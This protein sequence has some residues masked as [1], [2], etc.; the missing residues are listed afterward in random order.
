MSA[1][2]QL[3]YLSFDILGNI[4]HWNIVDL[5]S[6]EVTDKFLTDKQMADNK[7]LFNI[8][9]IFMCMPSYTFIYE[10]SIITIVI[11]YYTY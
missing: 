3:Q 10:L 6:I 5:L 8:D 9:N 11:F 4:L 1:P 7:E 2:T